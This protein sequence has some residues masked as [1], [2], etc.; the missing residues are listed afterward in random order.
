MQ[1]TIDQY[2][3]IYAPPAQIIVSAAAGSGKTQVLTTRII[4]RIKDEKNPISVDKLLIVTFTKAAAA[5]MR[6][7]IGKALRKAISAES[8]TVLRDHLKKQLMLLGSAHICTIDSFCY[9]VVK[10]N[11]FKENLPSDISIGESGEL[12]LLRLASLEE[13]VNSLYCAMEKSKGNELSEE[14]AEYA[15]LPGKYFPDAEEFN[16]ILRGF[17]QLTNAFSSDKKDSDFSDNTDFG[18]DYTNMISELYKRSQSAAYPGDWLNYIANLYSDDTDITNTEIFTNTFLH[19]KNM[20]VNAKRLIENLIEVSIANEIGYEKTFSKDIEILE[21]LSCAKNYDDLYNLYTSE[22]SFS[23]MNQR[24]RGCDAQTALQI[25]NARNDIISTLKKKLGAVFQFSLSDWKS[26]KHLLYPQIKALCAAAI[27]LDKIYYEKMTA[28]RIIDFSAC[29][30][31]ALKIISEDGINLTD[32]GEALK[33]KY[34]EI[35]IDEFQD[36]NDLQDKLFTLISNGKTFC[37]GDVKQSI[38]GFRNADPTIFMQKCDA[39]SF[40][41]DAEKRKIFLSKNF[42]STKNVIDAVNAVFDIVMIPEAAKIDYKSEHRLDFGGDFIKTEKHEKCEIVIVQKNGNASVQAGN[43][44]Q[45]IATAIKKLLNN[46]QTVYD[47]DTEALRPVRYSDIT[48]LMSAPKPVS[49]IYEKVF[50]ENNI[51]HFFD[52]GNDLYESSEVGQIIEI[53]KL[54]DNGKSDIPLASTLRSPMF[55]FDEAELLKI[56]LSSNKSFHE[57]F[58]GI[59]RGEFTVEPALAKKCKLFMKQ[60]SFWRKSAGFVTVQELIRR[61]YNDTGIYSTTLALSDGDMRR[62]NLDL[63]LEQAEEFERSSYTGLF[64]F[65]TYVEKMKKTSDNISEAKA[66]SEKMNV[67]RIMS[68]HKSK[69]CEFP[70]VFLAGAAKSYHGA[71]ASTGGL[72]INQHYGI[73]INYVNPVLRYKH[74]TPMQR[75]LMLMAQNDEYAEEMRLL[76][77]ALTRAREKLYVVA[78]LKN[79]EA[80]ENMGYS[81]ID[82]LTSNEIANASSFIA[83]M[84][85]AYPRGAD[86]FWSVSEVIPEQ[87]AESDIDAVADVKKFEEDKSLSTLLEY[88]YPYSDYV[89]LPGKASVSFLKTIDINLSSSDTGKVTLLNSTSAKQAPFSKPEFI[90]EEHSG[91][92]IG[93]VHHKFLQYCNYTEPVALQLKNMVISKIITEEEAK[94]IQ[95]DKLENFFSSELGKTIKNAKTLYREEA[96]VI[97]VKANEID[98]SL[99]EDETICVQGIIDCYFEKDD[100][101]IVLVDYKT[102]K[103]NDPSE[104]IKKYYKQLYYYEKALKSKFKNKL[105][106][107]YLYLIHKNDIIEL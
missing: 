55:M 57:S 34:D 54:I 92:Y 83:L 64:N 63:L 68:I 74:N 81:V 103:Y 46:G 84:A 78:T 40:D 105:I 61:I 20:I 67:V 71:K 31:I 19:S 88:Q 52:G 5:E 73:G 62:A 11:F 101:T 14:N 96:F 106:Q 45:Y 69:G 75:A 25:K 85:L 1:W 39:S 41:D 44:A 22:F 43:E 47:K 60:L 70:I 72:I 38:Y 10:Q 2:N 6:E 91:A 58:Y 79:F 93:T 56:K 59:C 90:S 50:T 76:Y 24:K 51:P 94:L 35:Y 98:A 80:F 28:R 7:R 53:L 49:A 21:Q 104:I 4:E 17:E 48:V 36:S 87:A 23:N 32:V 89:N 18:G 13:T 37:V 29:E 100:S 15:E 102:D 82:N 95:I 26:L 33:Q 27:L 30:H 12:S 77:V 16:L 97:N 42:R 65:V 107:K 86:K 8:D 9:D 3:S 66:V 99:K